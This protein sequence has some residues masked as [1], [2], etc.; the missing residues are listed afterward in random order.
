MT[1]RLAPRFAALALG[2]FAV[3]SQADDAPV[4]SD[5]WA[6]ATAPGLDVGAAY[7][8]IQGGDRADRLV[9]AT[10]ER[11]AMVHVHTVEE[12]AGVARM[13]AIDAIEVP[14]RGRVVL[15]PKST[16]LMLMGLTGPLVAGQ[17]FPITLRFATAGAQT[18]IVAVREATAADDPAQQRH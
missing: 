13:R 2:A 16:H 10:S 7:M 18:V 14:A 11:A 3:A 5:A 15:A 1:L 8:V 4:V 6:R 12:Q 9:A 17:S